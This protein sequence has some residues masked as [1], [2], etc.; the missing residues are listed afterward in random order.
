MIL[1]LS[2]SKYEQTTIELINWLDLYKANYFRINGSDLINYSFVNLNK[3]KIKL[4]E[5]DIDYNQIK[6]IFNRRWIDDNE[7]DDP[8]IRPIHIPNIEINTLREINMSEHQI[9]TGYVYDLL[10]HAEWIPRHKSINK[11]IVLR[12]ALEFGLQ[13]PATYII[14]QKSDLKKLYK[15][16]NGEIITKSIGD[17]QQIFIDDQSL[18]FH[19]SKIDNEFLNKVPNAFFPSLV[20]ENVCKEYEVRVFYFYEKMYSMA[21]FSQLDDQ[22]S[23]DFRNYNI[24]K[25]NRT[26]PYQLPNDIQLKLIEL[27]NSLNLNTGSIDLIANSSGYVFL[28]VNP[29]GQFG[30]VDYP[31]N[32]GLFEI[33]ALKLIELDEK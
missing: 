5:R 23:V 18:I 27:M 7:F 25:K 32:Y 15:K 17:I 31:C 6:V 10:K 33:I 24:S 21:I 11:L 13:I 9:L 3:S 26:V 20:Q 14:T 30:M 12:R 28:E 19:T 16:F 29:V 2:K 4:A 22:T 8:G 1:I